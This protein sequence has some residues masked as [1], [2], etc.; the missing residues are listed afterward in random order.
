MKNFKNNYFIIIFS[1]FASLAFSQG[2][3]S[4][5]IL[6]AELN[7]GLPGV[8]VLIK[9]TTDG[10]TTDVDGKFSISTKT[11]SGQLIIT[12][13]GFQ[14]KTL[15]FSIEKNGVLDLGVIR[16]NPE[17]NQLEEI[18]IKSSVIDIAKDRK[19]PIAVSTI[20]SAEIIEKLGSQEFP[21]ILN[22]TPSV[23]VTKTGG[24]FG[25]SRINIRGFSQENIAVMINGVPVN[26]MENSRVFWS[27]WAGLSDV[28]SAMQVQRGL[29]SSKLAISS[30]GGTINVVTKTSDLKQGGT[31]SSTIGND[32]YLKTL[33]SYSSGK[34]ENGFSASLLISQTFGDGFVDG[35]KFAAANYF[36]ALGYELNKKHDFQI[37]FTGAPQWHN[38]RSAA[39]TISDYIKYGEGG[40]EPNIRYNS[41]WGY[42]DGKEYSFRTNY[43]HK[44]VASLNWDW[45][46][47][48]STKLST[49]VYGS[50]GRGGGSNGTGAI[51]GNRFFAPNLRK[52]DGTIDV[53]LIQAWNSGQNV[54]IIPSS[55][56]QIPNNN[57]RA[58]IGGLY[59]NSNS[60][61][62]NGTN[63]I[64]KISSINS[65]NWYGG[66]INLNK[67]FNDKLM[68][69][70]GLDAR[71][72]R[73]IHF[74]NINDL[75]GADNFAD[76]FDVNNP[77]RVL[78]FEH[79]TKPH[80]NPLFNS[81]YQQ[82]INYNND[83][84]VRWYGL[85]TQLEY[86]TEK[87]TAFIQG[88][89]SQQGFRRD[90]YFKYLTTDP[91]YSTDYE[92]LLGGNIKGGLNY[93]INSNHNVFVNAG[94]YSKQPFFNAVFPNNA[95]I[96]NENLTN[97]KILGVE[98]GYGFRSSKFSANLN[99]YRTSWKDRFI[100]LT[101]NID[102]DLNSATPTILGNAFL[103]GVEQ[104]HIGGEFDF[105]YKPIKRIAIN[106]MFSLGNW[107]YGSN[108]VANYQDDNNIVIT[109]PSGDVFTETLYIDGLKVGDAAQTTASIG[110]SFEVVERV[111][112]DGNYRFVDE[113][114]ASID[115]TNFR[116]QAAND[117]GSLLL[118]SYGLVDAGF[119]YKMLVGKD[120]S[121]SVNFRL[122]VNNLLDEI[123]ISE[124]RTNIHIKNQ[125]DFLN[126]DGTPNTT[127]YN[128]YLT[129]LRTYDGLDQTNQVYF[130]FGRTWNFSISYNF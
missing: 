43:Y 86:S 23:Y 20:K 107:K 103:Q 6:D 12:Y 73:G 88:A 30:V 16:L 63:G 62:N 22:N 67:K 80:F 14:T 77:N 50:W 70:F 53:D 17:S 1:L 125:G 84:L 75:L 49:V 38:Q 120:K 116:T 79:S 81:D 35:T 128:T 31:F 82:K 36:V 121:N 126:S 65:H 122:N 123:Y 66:I 72:Y 119:S 97:E 91:L 98:A 90:D 33:A 52:P 7:G 104:I 4:G 64:S 105:T 109:N 9:G 76:N 130:G 40:N 78:T 87:L 71:T 51:R 8:N 89:V 93:N 69:D 10:T 106:G 124:S 45:K 58:T 27:N 118:P 100:R 41:D 32:D 111:K 61:S 48:E 92:N 55:G 102:N 129:N 110:A 57:P 101:A 24:G 74:Q 15:N 39:P 83:G 56:P 5:T 112:I 21:E 11:N 34:L 28:T 18:V 95:S 29:G 85:F 44:P 68:L 46:I 25:D 117:K 47:N 42:L 3:V 60:T 26:D 94:Y 108:V 54:S 96:V 127:N 113:L 59:Q 115:P 2:K 37:T 13:I 114:Y 99:F 19:T